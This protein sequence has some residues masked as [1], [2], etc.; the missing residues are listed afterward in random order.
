MKNTG[1]PPELTAGLSP[2]DLNGSLTSVLLSDSLVFKPLLFSLKF[3]KN[4]SFFGLYDLSPL[5][6]YSFFSFL[7][8]LWGS[9]SFFNDSNLFWGSFFLPWVSES[10]SSFLATT[11][12]P[13]SGNSS[14][15]NFLPFFELLALVPLNTGLYLPNVIPPASLVSLG[16]SFFASE[17]P[18]VAGCSALTPLKS[19]S[20]HLATSTSF[21]TST[22]A[23]LF[24]SSVSFPSILNVAFHAVSSSSCSFSCCFFAFF[25]S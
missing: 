25:S 14:S 6:L 3:P 18:T 15:L 8:S 12:P 2:S 7:S 11:A 4:S 19:I 20:S 24:R 5:F 1:G 17:T 23:S 16:A 10:F 21:V 13:I 9:S 22:F